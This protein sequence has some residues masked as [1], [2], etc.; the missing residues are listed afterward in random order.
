MCIITRDQGTLIEHSCNKYMIKLNQYKCNP[1]LSQF[2]SKEESRWIK[3]KPYRVYACKKEVISIA[4]Q[5]SSCEKG[6]NPQKVRYKIK[7]GGQDAAVMM[8]IPGLK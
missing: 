3:N 7:G 2:S 8:I 1:L 4:Q 5:Q 6:W